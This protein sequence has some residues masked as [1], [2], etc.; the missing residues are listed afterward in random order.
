[1]V[2]KVILNPYAGRWK[3]LRMRSQLESALIHAGINYE[4]VLTE[5]PQHGI[6]LAYQAVLEGFSPILS[7]GGDG[8]MSEVVNGVVKAAQ[9][10]NTPPTPVGI[11]PLGTANDLMVNLHLPLEL[12][13]AVS[14]VQAGYTRYIDLGK[15]TAWDVSGS[16]QTRFFDNNSAIGIEPSITLIQQQIT[17]LR[18]TFRYL[19]A[20][21]IG[22]TRN[23]QWTMK[24]EW[25]GGEYSGPCTIVTAGN[26]PLTGGLFYM[27]PHADPFDGFLSIVF[28]HM[29]TRR[30]ILQLLPRA[31]K[32]G[33]GSYVEH[34]AIHEISTKWMK[35]TTDPATPIHADGEIMFEKCNRL[36]YHIL[37]AYL[38]IFIYAP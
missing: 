21:L 12:E 17:W 2:A 38:P 14:V 30:K 3:G 27:A 37:P 32:P 16:S 20:T 31:M 19:L 29:A 25:E 23:P 13:Q 10:T 5:R 34:P 36:E 26:N 28:G 35:I 22:V 18:G 11:F 7:A 1:M 4:L 24:I 6:E 15:V 9:E 8:S 33:P